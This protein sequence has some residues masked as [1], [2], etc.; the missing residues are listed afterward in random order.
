[1][2]KILYTLTDEAPALATYSFLPIVEAFASKAG[3]AVETRDISLSGRILAAMAEVLPQDQTAHDA[4]AELGALAQTPEANIVKLPNISASIPQLKAAIAELQEQ[5]FDLPDYP[6]DP[7]NEAERDIKA[8][9][10]KV[11]GSAVNPVLREGNSDRRAPKAVK[12]YAQKHPHRMGAWSSDSLARVA[13]MTAGDFYGS[14]QSVT[15]AS[16]TT[17]D[18]VHVDEAGGRTVLKEGL[19]LQAGE[20]VDLPSCPWPNWSRS[21]LRKSTRS[22]QKGPC[23][24]CT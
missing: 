10:D 4:L 22:K 16:A 9:Y 15:M 13:S 12:T 7:S 5:G 18:I 8:K 24:H 14:E 11:K 19:A 23:F 21:W 20:I 17:V 6:D 1:M 3:V 2:S